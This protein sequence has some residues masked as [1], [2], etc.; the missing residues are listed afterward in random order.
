MILTNSP[1]EIVVQYLL[2]YNP[3]IGHE[4]SGD[5]TEWPIFYSQVTSEPD[6]TI[7]VFDTGGRPD[8]RLGNTR[9]VIEH[10]GIQVRIRA[11]SHRE[12]WDKIKQV[13]A[14]LDAVQRTD[15]LLEEKTYRIATI[16]R[17]GTPL[18][19][20]PEPQSDRFRVLFTINALLSVTEI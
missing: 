4:P 9:Q 11:A 15:V 19:L 2:G 13:A 1:A 6:N 18:F 5:P 3:E 17:Q 10:P 14:A 20:G 7:V 12:A 16:T 8:G